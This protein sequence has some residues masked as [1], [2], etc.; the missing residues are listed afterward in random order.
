MVFGPPALH[1]MGQGCTLPPEM[2]RR[3]QPIPLD[4]AFAMKIH[5]HRLHGHAIAPRAVERPERGGRGWELVCP[6]AFE[7][8]WNGGPRPEDLEIRV[9]GTNEDEPSFVQSQLGHGVLTFHPGYQF[10]TEEPYALWVG[11]PTGAPKDGIALLE[12]LV[13]A[14]HL[15][16]TVAVHWQLTRA[17]HTLRFAAGEPFAQLQLHPRPRPGTIP[18]AVARIE[19]A[20]ESAHA[21][22]LVRMV[23]TTALDSVFLRLGAEKS[24]R[25]AAPRPAEAA[26]D[27]LPPGCFDTIDGRLDLRRLAPDFFRRDRFL[28]QFEDAL[29]SYGEVQ[30]REFFVIDERSLVFLSVPKVA[31]TAIKLALAKARGIE[32]PADKSLEQHVHV[33]SSWHR[34]QGTLR[35]AQD[36][37]HRFAFVRNP[38]DR[39]V[40]CYRSKILFRESPTHRVPL[41]EG[42]FFSL[43]VNIAFDDF[44]RRVAGI[45]DALADNHFKSQYALLHERGELLVDELG[46]FEHLDEHWRSLAERYGLDPVLGVSNESKR[47]PGVHG[48]F[49]RYYTEELVQLVYERYRRDVHTFGYE[50]AYQELLAFARERSHEPA[51]ELRR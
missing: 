41:Y 24:L 48:D 8:T 33:L 38:F 19:H 20:D 6:H 28:A 44:A 29:R 47:Q 36:G 23:D 16:C 3:D 18:L 12:S 21:Q 35:P 9:E 50:A 51:E 37:H 43:P 26:T 45:P 14:T 34:E 31:C 7:I 25:P 32:V 27:P 2:G 15:P 4:D 10:K 13:D 42:Y 46:R 22:D 30:R 11:G 39:L 1:P 5:A 40:S 17:H 49:R